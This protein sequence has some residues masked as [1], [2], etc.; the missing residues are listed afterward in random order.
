MEGI[1]S[2][3]GFGSL[4]FDEVTGVELTMESGASEHRPI[5]KQAQL[6]VEQPNKRR[7]KSICGCELL[8]S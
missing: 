3:F 5:T 4:V 2:V 1:S 7:Q 6:N 8:S